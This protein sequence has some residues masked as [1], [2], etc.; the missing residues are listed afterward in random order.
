MYVPKHISPSGRRT[1]KANKWS[2]TGI[3]KCK[4]KFYNLICGYQL[5]IQFLILKG[6]FT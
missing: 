5:F 6:G 1:K 4:R 3:Q 2:V